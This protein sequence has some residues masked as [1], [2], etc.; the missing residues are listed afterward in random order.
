VA[1]RLH[2]RVAASLYVV[3]ALPP[4]YSKETAR[5]IEAVSQGFGMIA[6]TSLAGDCGG[7]GLRMG[8][9]SGRLAAAGTSGMRSTPHP[10][11]LVA[12]M[13]PGLSSAR[14]KELTNL[15]TQEFCQS[16]MASGVW[17]E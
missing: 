10:F 14:I 4:V 7:R 9:C 15:C 5:Q 3:L 8:D 11:M 1:P 13:A 6:T 16:K 2:R 12:L 17:L